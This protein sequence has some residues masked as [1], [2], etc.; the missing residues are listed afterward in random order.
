MSDTKEKYSK[1]GVGADTATTEKPIANEDKSNQQ[2]ITEKKSEREDESKKSETTAQVTEV[3]EYRNDS[4][5]IRNI[6]LKRWRQYEIEVK[7]VSTK[8][9]EEA[10]TI[11]E[12]NTFFWDC[13]DPDNT[14]ISQTKFCNGKDD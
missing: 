4:I 14:K 7:A 12:F 13:E 8:C 1:E 5:P 11:F 3:T 10:K 2:G 9:G 6:T